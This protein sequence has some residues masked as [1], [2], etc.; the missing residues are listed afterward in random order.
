MAK[1]DDSL[2]AWEGTI[3]AF[4]VNRLA[5]AMIKTT[6]FTRIEVTRVIIF[7]TDITSS[8]MRISTSNKGSITNMKQKMISIILTDYEMGKISNR[9][10]MVYFNSLVKVFTQCLFSYQNMLKNTI[11]LISMWIIRHKHRFISSFWNSTIVMTFNKSYGLSLFP[12]MF[13]IA[14]WSKVSSLTTSTL[15]ETIKYFHIRLQ[16][17]R[18]ISRLM[19][20]VAIRPLLPLLSA[21]VFRNK[22]A[23]SRISLNYTP[24]RKYCQVGCR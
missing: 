1:K 21:L 18:L 9:W 17:K 4:L 20:A 24:M 22:K 16:I 5:L 6:F 2:D 12:S 11:L 19:R 8:P 13:R 23:A 14:A 15:A 7:F 10:K 3:S